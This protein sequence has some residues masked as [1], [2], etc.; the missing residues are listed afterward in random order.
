MLIHVNG[1]LLA[2][3]NTPEA[4]SSLESLLLNFPTDNYDHE[5]LDAFLYATG[6]LACLVACHLHAHSPVS[7]TTAL[8][9][10]LST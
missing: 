3:V 5:P 10:E 4:G 1:R 6:M 8:I 9:G 2:T 7:L